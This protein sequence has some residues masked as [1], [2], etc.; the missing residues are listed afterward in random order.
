MKFEI[1][2]N[3]SESDDQIILDGL[4]E[5]NAQILG[6]KST[7]FTIFAKDRDTIIA[8][9]SI[10]EHSDALYIKYLWVDEKFRGQNVGATLLNMADDCARQKKLKAIHA[11]TYSF[12]AQEFYEKHGFNVID[13]IENYLLGHDRVFL[14]KEVL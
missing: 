2:T 9:A 1:N 11:D 8:G 5:F 14:K 6:E 13:V 4:N 12:Q 10:W 7:H 3:P